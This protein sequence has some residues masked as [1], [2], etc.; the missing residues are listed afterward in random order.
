MGDF[1]FACT[2]QPIATLLTGV[3]RGC[4]KFLN[5]KGIETSKPDHMTPILGQL[6]QSIVNSSNLQ[7]TG[8]SMF[9]L[10]GISETWNGYS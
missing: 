7:K 1:S 9:F 5:L 8:E 2:E 3:L 4:K 6:C 10:R